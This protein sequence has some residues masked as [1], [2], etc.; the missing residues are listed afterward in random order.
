MNRRILQCVSMLVI[1]CLCMVFPI[2]TAGAEVDLISMAHNVRAYSSENMSVMV[3]ELPNGVIEY[4]GSDTMHSL[5][6]TIVCCGLRERVIG[7]NERVIGIGSFIQVNNVFP[8]HWSDVFYIGMRADDLDEVL[9]DDSMRADNIEIV[10][11]ADGDVERITCTVKK[12]DAFPE[13]FQLAFSVYAQQ[14]YQIEFSF[15][16]PEAED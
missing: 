11:A 6:N 14:V 7:L 8:L 2:G 9:R 1:G 5:N 10:R 12:S 3:K 13:D 4:R 15:L 16:T